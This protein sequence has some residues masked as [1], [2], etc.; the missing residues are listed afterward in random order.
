MSSIFLHGPSNRSGRYKK[1][2]PSTAVSLK[3]IRALKMLPIESRSF[4]RGR[5]IRPMARGEL[6]TTG[7]GSAMPSR[8]S[9]SLSAIANS[10]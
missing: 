6:E 3:R 8:V 5:N 10:G 9:T 4:R 7:L 1:R 2:Q